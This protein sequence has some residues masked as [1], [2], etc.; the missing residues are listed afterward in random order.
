MKPTISKH[1]AERQAERGI[2]EVGIRAILASSATAFLPS[3]TDPEVAIVL[4][5]YKSNVWAVLLNVETLNV[6]TVRRAS[7]KEV[8][9]YEQ[10]TGN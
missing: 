5:K 3:N 1:A 7:K 9:Y 4:G 6:I 10:K 8:K 2:T